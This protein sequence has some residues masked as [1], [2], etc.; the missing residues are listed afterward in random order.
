M[1]GLRRTEQIQMKGPHKAK[2]TNSNER[3]G[4]AGSL[5]TPQ[6]RTCAPDTIGDIMKPTINFRRW[7]PAAFTIQNEAENAF[8]IQVSGRVLW[9][10]EQLLTAG[11]KGCTP[12]D[13][14]APRWS[15]YVFGLRE[16]GV[17]IE[18]IHEAHKGPFAGMHA[19]YVLRSHVVPSCGGE[20]AA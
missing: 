17:L 15:G 3:A 5:A 7:K 2:P 12:I 18:T 20:V 1:R 14:P 8:T 19:R 4:F 6:Y 9:T 13:N 11:G 16:L 10:L